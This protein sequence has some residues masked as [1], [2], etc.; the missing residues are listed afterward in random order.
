MKREFSKSMA[1]DEKEELQGYGGSE[2]ESP[3]LDESPVSP[4]KKAG[5]IRESPKWKQSIN[6]SPSWRGLVQRRSTFKGNF[7]VD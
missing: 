4:M 6:S 5:R 1:I 7:G 2:I 3:I